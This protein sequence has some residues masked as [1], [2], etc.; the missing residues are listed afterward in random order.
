[1]GAPAGILALINSV[2]LVLGIAMIG[3]SAYG[4]VE[5]QNYGE[6]MSKDGFFILIAMGAIAMIISLLGICGALQKNKLMLLIYIVAMLVIVL[7]QL[8]MGVLTMIWAG[9]VDL[10]QNNKFVAD[11]TDPFIKRIDNLSN[12][13]WNACCQGYMNN[14]LTPGVDAPCDLQLFTVQPAACVALNQVLLLEP[15][16][17]ATAGDFKLGVA[18]YFKGKVGTM[19]TAAI[20]VIVCEVIALFFAMGLLCKKKD[21]LYGDAYVIPE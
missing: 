9:R 11:Q 1:M 7:G 17:C 5:F 14:T 12:C 13:T 18:E 10:V 4:L 3:V 21:E 2:F 19:A 8:I 16:K 6:F 20:I 15:A